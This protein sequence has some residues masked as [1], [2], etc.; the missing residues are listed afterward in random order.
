METQEKRPS[1][2][3]AAWLGLLLAAVSGGLIGLVGSFF[4]AFHCTSGDGGAPYVARD[5]LQADVCGAAGEGLWLFAVQLLLVLVLGVLS[6]RAVSAWRRR[7]GSGRRAL[8]LALG[9]ALVPL[10]VFL[11]A[12]Q[13]SDQ[14]S[15][16][17][18]EAVEEWRDSG[19]RGDP[20]F[21]CDTY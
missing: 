12:N 1:G 5:S 18:R 16:D 4:F 14:C 9:I 17:K 11:A 10:S 8:L 21:D 15:D 20:P 2:D 19:T 7:E 13:P 6:I 3:A